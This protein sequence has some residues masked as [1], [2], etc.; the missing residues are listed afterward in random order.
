MPRPA[1]RYLA[2]LRM[3]GLDLAG[4][5]ELSRSF[6][7]CLMCIIW[8]SIKPDCYCLLIAASTVLV[9]AAGCAG[10]SCDERLR[11]HVDVPRHA[12]EHPPA[13]RVQHPI[14]PAA[15]TPGRGGEQLQRVPGLS[16]PHAPQSL[17][18]R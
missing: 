18:A 9:E 3:T 5:E 1:D 14:A 7:P 6:E 12:Q 8:Q 11:L 15:N 10:H 4:G 2:A 17:P 16:P 13:L